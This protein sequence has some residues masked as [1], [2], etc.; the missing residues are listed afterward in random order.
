MFLVVVTRLQIKY[1]VKSAAL[2][3]VPLSNKRRIRN[4]QRVN[5]V[6]ETLGL[7]TKYDW[8]GG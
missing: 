4:T 7:V 8:L 1:F 3:Q 2:E 5:T 6:I